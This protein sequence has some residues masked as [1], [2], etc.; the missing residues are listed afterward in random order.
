MQLAVSVSQEPYHAPKGAADLRSRELGGWVALWSLWV[1]IYQT[2]PGYR[3]SRSRRGTRLISTYVLHSTL[4]QACT[5]C[6]LAQSK[7]GWN[8]LISMLSMSL[9]CAKVHQGM[10]LWTRLA[11]NTLRLS[12]TARRSCIRLDT[13][14]KPS[15]VE[16]I[17]CNA[18]LPSKVMHM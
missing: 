3:R 4:S 11:G 6:W 12:K 13:V 10:S 18:M 16:S 17:S 8:M 5:P 2:L 14:A 9:F 7:A 1:D 15:H